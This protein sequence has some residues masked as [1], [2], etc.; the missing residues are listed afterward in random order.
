M[1]LERQIL[2]L[3]AKGWTYRRISEELD[4][5][6]WAINEVLRKHGLAHA[7]RRLSRDDELSLMRL[8]LAG[9]SIRRAARLSSWSRESINRV[10]KRN[11][12]VIPKAKT[13]SP[14]RL[15]LK[16]REEISR[17][18]VAS[19]S[20]NEIG[21]RLERPASTISREVSAN[22]GRQK[23]RAWAAQARAEQLAKRP[24]T[25]KLVRCKELHDAVSSYLEARLSP[26]QIAARLVVDHPDNPEMRISHEAIYQ[27]LFI[28]GRGALR[29]ELAACLRTGRAIRKPQKR[30]Q[31][32]RIPNMV[33][34]SE[35]PAEIEDRAIPG[36]WEGDL[37]IGKDN[38]SA[39]GTLVERS[40]R[41][42]MLMKLKNQKAETVRD[43]LIETVTRLPEELFKTLTRTRSPQPTEIPEGMFKTLTWDQGIE[44][45]KH[46][47]F[48]ISTGVDVYFCDP[49]SPWQRGSNENTNGLL[50]QYFPKG[51]SLS[52]H[53]QEHLDA[54]ARQLNNR[55]RQTL[56]WQNPAERLAE[57]IAL[58]G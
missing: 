6:H 32:G 28:Q 47:E 33:M 53:P 44:M 25:A 8:L 11:G 27:S 16:D 36:H 51:T 56:G 12:G 14:L 58:T 30:E 23:Y 20:F 39:I 19:A 5:S 21:R 31:R 55:P 2:S 22:G 26:Q 24:K 34:I 38:K 7:Q 10:I 41:Y 29:R 35:R 1:A 4:C 46:A 37:I 50:R 3:Q 17:L 49:R 57:F 40:S 13:C 43:A 42:V 18:L 52:G 48:S 15:S 45:A 9:N 54:V